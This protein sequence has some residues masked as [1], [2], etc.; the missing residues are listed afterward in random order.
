MVYF[1]V[2]IPTLSLAFEVCAGTPGNGED[3]P[4]GWEGFVLQLGFLDL[5]QRWWWWVVFNFNLG[6]A[7]LLWICDLRDCC[8]LCYLQSWWGVCYLRNLHGL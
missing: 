4:M 1:P 5:L 3:C 6:A 8:R 2:V 7:I